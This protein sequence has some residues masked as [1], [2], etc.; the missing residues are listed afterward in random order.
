[1]IERAALPAAPG[2]CG[3]QHRAE[4][5]ALPAERSL[6]EL[7]GVQKQANA[8]VAPTPSRG[9]VPVTASKVTPVKVCGEG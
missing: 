2:K 1:M 7:P 4:K 3:H 5:Q 6:K 9:F 8:Q